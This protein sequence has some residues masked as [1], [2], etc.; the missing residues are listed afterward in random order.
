MIQHWRSFLGG[1]NDAKERIVEDIQSG[2]ALQD[3]I[4]KGAKPM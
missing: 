1:I 2:A 4:A 3:V